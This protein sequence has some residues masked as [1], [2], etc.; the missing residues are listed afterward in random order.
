MSVEFWKSASLQNIFNKK[1]E[2][3]GK[4][5]FFFLHNKNRNCLTIKANEMHNLSDLFDKVLYIFRTGLLSV[6]RSISTLY[7][8]NKYLSC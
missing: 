8:R 3:C 7:T 5:W 4:L 1:D 2:N 6:I